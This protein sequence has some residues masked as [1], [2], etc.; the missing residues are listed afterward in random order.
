MSQTIRS[1]A[2]CIF[3]VCGIAAAALLL[4]FS[5]LPAQMP[6][7]AM[8]DS[9]RDYVSTAMAAFRSHSVHRSQV[10]WAALEDS[11]LTRA[12]NARTPAE[13]WPVLTWALRRVDRHSFLMSARQRGGV[14]LGRGSS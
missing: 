13:T 2:V 5:P 14:R 9:V 7:S 11:V 4:V 12:V 10:D 3:R 8:P 6:Q 1:R